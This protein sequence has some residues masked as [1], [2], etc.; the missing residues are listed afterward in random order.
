MPIDTLLY[1]HVNVVTPAVTT[2]GKKLMNLT[3]SFTSKIKAVINAQFSHLVYQLWS[4]L[5]IE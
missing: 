1:S 5:V 3:P 4:D 2:Q